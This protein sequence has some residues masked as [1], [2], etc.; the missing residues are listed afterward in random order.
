MRSEFSGEKINRPEKGETKETKK[1]RYNSSKRRNEGDVFEEVCTKRKHMLL[2]G[3]VCIVTCTYVYLTPTF[4][5]LAK[6]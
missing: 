3:W 6:P 2:Y 4:I 1:K 5:S